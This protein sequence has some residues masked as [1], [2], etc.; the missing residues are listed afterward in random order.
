MVWGE[1]DP[2][3]SV[4]KDFSLTFVLKEQMELS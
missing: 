4:I 2:D 3:G 1:E